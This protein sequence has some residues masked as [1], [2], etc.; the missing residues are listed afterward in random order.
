PAV[1]RLDPMQPDTQQPD[2]VA[3]G[4]RRR[5]LRAQQV[6]R[7]HGDHP[8]VI[9]RGGEAALAR[10]E[11][12]I[13]PLHLQLHRA[14]D[15][16]LATYTSGDDLGLFADALAGA[17]QVSDIARIGILVRDALG[18]AMLG[19]QRAIVL[20]VGEAPEPVTMFAERALHPL[21]VGRRVAPSRRSPRLLQP[22]ARMWPHAV[23][24]ADRQ[25]VEEGALGGGWNDQ[26]PIRL[27]GVAGQLGDRFAARDP[28]R[29]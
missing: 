29:D 2:A 3:L 13:P 10:H 26:Q 7:G 18:W 6:D 12:E 23:E 1:K 4:E 27:T 15:E 9:G 20:G 28:Y 22:R 24:L 5:D 8:G 21:R 14:S 16:P 17:V 25:R 19:L 11:R